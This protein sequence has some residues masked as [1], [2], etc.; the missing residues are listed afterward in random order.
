MP[1]YFF[2]INGERPHR[3]E[4]G[5][6]LADDGDAW[7]EAMGRARDIEDTLRPGE[8]WRLDVREGNFVVYVVT[9]TTQRRR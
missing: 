2:H 7:H 3:D 8:A 6:E 1:R 5:E 9:I 4:I